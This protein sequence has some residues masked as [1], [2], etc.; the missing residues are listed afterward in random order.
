MDTST[1][2]VQTPPLSESGTPG[3]IENDSPFSVSTPLAAD[4]S[5]TDQIEVQVGDI[6]PRE[7]GR[8]DQGDGRLGLS[9][10]GSSDSSSNASSPPR[11][12]DIMPS[13]MSINS[14]N[15]PS[16]FNDV[17]QMKG[18]STSL[19]VSSNP[20]SLTL[21][22]FLETHPV[23]AP[24]VKNHQPPWRVRAI[25]RSSKENEVDSDI[26]FQLSARGV[27]LAYV[28]FD[29][30]TPLEGE[31]AEHCEAR[32][33]LTEAL[34]GAWG[35]LVSR[36]WEFDAR[37]SGMGSRGSSDLI[38]LCS[39]LLRLLLL[40]LRFRSLPSIAMDTQ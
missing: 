9:G 10:L 1:A 11:I 7:G 27:E 35:V 16:T 38:H 34:E 13:P 21:P 22:P 40:H 20:F 31:S 5:L 3:S 15:S 17:N 33:G 29:Q 8:I 2:A 30:L 32:S 37:S 4:S 12:V 14:V 6:V 25:L 28:D 18:R 23:A 19:G 39:T 24:D 36:A 26:A